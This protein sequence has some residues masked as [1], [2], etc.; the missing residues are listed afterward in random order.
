MLKALLNEDGLSKTKIL[1]RGRLKKWF[2]ESFAIIYKKIIFNLLVL[3]TTLIQQ[4][5]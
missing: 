4:T 3:I 5:I 2:I 1:N